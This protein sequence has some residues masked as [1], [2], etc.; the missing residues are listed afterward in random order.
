M[1]KNALPPETP[2]LCPNARPKLKSSLIWGFP[3]EVGNVFDSYVE[4]LGVSGLCPTLESFVAWISNYGINPTLESLAE[5]L[6]E[7]IGNYDVYAYLNSSLSLDMGIGYKSIIKS[8]IGLSLETKREN[9]LNSMLA[10]ALETRRNNMFNRSID[11]SLE[12]KRNNVLDRSIGLSLETGRNNVFN[13]SLN[14]SLETRK[15]NVFGHAVDLSFPTNPNN[16][17]SR[18]LS[19]LLLK[20]ETRYMRNDEILGIQETGYYDEITL[21]LN[22]ELN[23]WYFGI[24]AYILHADNS[25]TLISG[26]NAV[27]IASG[28]STGLKTGANWSCSENSM[29][30]TDKIRIEAY[31]DLNNPPTTLR[32]TFETEVLSA[33]QLDAAQW[34]AY[35]YLRRSGTIHNYNYYFDYG[36]LTQNSRIANFKWSQVIT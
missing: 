14:L 4:W 11:L 21:Q 31:C 32:Q 27:S 15:D 6:A 19:I 16:V 9:V 5:W 30:L 18:S 2:F 33:L 22:D 29:L 35:Y 10:L 20:N 23:T 36:G 7:T 8:G 25:T 26:A 1:S 12:T 17:L 24:K 3:I 28:N 34:I 13:R